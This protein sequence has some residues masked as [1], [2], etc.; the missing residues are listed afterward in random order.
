MT[1]TD[2]T[3]ALP[4]RYDQVLNQRFAEAMKTIGTH[5][6]APTPAGARRRPWALIA[7]SAVLAAAG[8]V[9]GLSPARARSSV[10]FAASN[11]VQVM[12]L[13]QGPAEF[14]PPSPAPP[15]PSP[16]ASPDA[17]VPEE[18]PSP[19]RVAATPASKAMRPKPPS[20]S[21][22]EGAAAESEATVE[23]VDGATVAYAKP[24]SPTPSVPPDGAVLFDE[25]GDGALTIRAASDEERP[26]RVVNL[27][28]RLAASL[29]Y[30]VRTGGASVPVTARV[31]A[32]VKVGDQIAIK[33]G[34]LLVGS[35][36]ATRDSDRVQIA[37][38]AIVRDGLT[39]R[40]QGVAL[41][42]DGEM[43][44]S[45]RLLRKASGGGSRWKARALG[46]AGSALSYDLARKTSGLTGTA[47]RE[48]A[49]DIDRDFDA[50]ERD[51]AENRSDKVVEAR[52]G[53]SL[54]V[55]LGADLDV[56]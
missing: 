37:F 54:V 17:A 31:D 43:G 45:G 9:M 12:G 50:F 11:T 48:L 49:S 26:R 53:A 14:I 27:G 51:W 5:G 55:C 7:G 32:D 22:L 6:A 2:R 13:A 8:M 39:S 23:D 29:V 41:G 21:G 25:D 24:A 47:A 4:S 35:A 28:T 33:A 42:A 56:P 36:I 40:F 44:I 46:A 34:S 52:A 38:A 18:T 19:K 20:L 16:S 10:P 15:S 1:P 30:P 3:P